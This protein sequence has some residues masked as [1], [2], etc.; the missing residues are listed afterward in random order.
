MHK[1]TNK[2]VSL[3]LSIVILL[4]ITFFMIHNINY[5]DKKYQQYKVYDIFEQDVALNA[6]KS[7]LGFFESDNEL[8]SNFFKPDEVSHL[9]DV[10]DFLNILRLILIVFLI[11][12]LFFLVFNFIQGNKIFDKL[13]FYT[14]TITISIFLFFG[15]IY[16]LLGFDFLFEAFHKIFFVENYAFDPRF[17]NMILLFPNKFFQDFM[18]DIIIRTNI[19]AIL[20][21]V[22]GK[23]IKK[24]N[25]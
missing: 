9:Q 7:I 18:F 25:I 13:F 3:F 12:V 15:L 2:F 4:S 20:M 6:T 8:D 17:S 24:K 11:I 19:S 23:I 5:Y 22:V 14:G 21:I 10:K 16:F 1:L